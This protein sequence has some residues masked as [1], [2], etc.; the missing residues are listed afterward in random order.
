[1][2]LLQRAAWVSL[3][4]V[5]CGGAEA[6]TSK[7]A[8]ASSVG[9]GGGRRTTTAVQGGS[10]DQTPT[11][12]KRSANGGA[13]PTATGGNR[14]AN[15]GA[16]PSPTGGNRSANGGAVPTATGGTSVANG[17]AVPT[18]TG[19]TNAA[20]GGAV[21]TATGGTN[22]AN[23]G[24]FPTA[25]GGTNAANGGAAAVSGGSPSGG[26]TSTRVTAG[27]PAVAGAPAAAG[28][29]AAAGAPAGP[30]LVEVA[31]GAACSPAGAKACV[32]G[33][34]A[35]VVICGASGLWESTTRCAAGRVCSSRRDELLGTC[36][37]RDCP[38]CPT[39]PNGSGEWHCMD[40]EAVAGDEVKCS[41]R[42]LVVARRK[43]LTGACYKGLCYNDYVFTCSFIAQPASEI[44]SCGVGC[45]PITE[46][47]P[48]WGPDSYMHGDIVAPP[49][50]G[51][52]WV[53]IDGSSD[54]YSLGGCPEVR[55]ILIDYLPAGASIEVPAPYWVGYTETLAELCKPELRTQRCVVYDPAYPMNPSGNLAI[56]TADPNAPPF[57]AYLNIFG[58]RDNGISYCY[59]NPE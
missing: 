21:P 42:G 56:L 50:T 14:S 13:A 20:N 25:T 2:A 36:R 59:P 8:G 4:A 1:M 10:Q 40:T 23:G 22:A 37:T 43:C 11:G 47:C 58:V 55:R 46:A 18:A 54:W 5:A 44:V 9:G 24:A 32:A 57:V 38:E 41:P 49:G 48:Y 26:V 52:R 45:A 51:R 12:G 3:I 31:V 29:S 28:A 27:A 6:G 7:G 34:V 16:A 35:A 30:E 15:G 19:G 39:C 53:Y 33:D 17:G